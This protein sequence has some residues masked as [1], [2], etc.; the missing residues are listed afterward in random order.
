MGLADGTL[1]QGVYVIKHWR[2]FDSVD[3]GT[4]DRHE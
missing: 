4:G 3:S 2:R 1:V